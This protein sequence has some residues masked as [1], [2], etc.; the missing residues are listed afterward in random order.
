[1]SAAAVGA[2][3][4]A[5]VTGL[6]LKREAQMRSA[7]AAAG[8]VEALKRLLPERRMA[9]LL[10][11]DKLNVVVK[12]IVVHRVGGLC[13]WLA[14]MYRMYRMGGCGRG[15]AGVRVTRAWRGCPCSSSYQV[16]LM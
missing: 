6:G 9:E 16:R 5:G 15:G 13:G 14:G 4:A 2:A 8:A 12:A 3:V 7:K 10:G 1:M 11:P